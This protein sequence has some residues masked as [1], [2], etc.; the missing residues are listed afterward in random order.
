MALSADFPW[1]EISPEGGYQV[2]DRVGLFYS[3]HERYIFDNPVG[4]VTRVEE[5][6]DDADHPDPCPRCQE[7]T[8]QIDPVTVYE[9]GDGTDEDLY[10][11]DRKATGS[12]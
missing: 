2:G 9:H 4:V 8:V 6:C 7:I 3:D 10:L 1:G 12:C 11:I 5:N